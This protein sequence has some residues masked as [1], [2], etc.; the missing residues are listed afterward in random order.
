MYTIGAEPAFDEHTLLVL[1]F[2]RQSRVRVVAAWINGVPLDVRK[3]QYPRNRALSCFYADL[4]G[5]AAVGG[6]NRLVIH[7]EQE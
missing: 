7:F 5:S 4:V 6:E 3:Y 2:V 1:P